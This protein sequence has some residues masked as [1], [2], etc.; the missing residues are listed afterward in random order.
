MTEARLDI[1]ASAGDT[2]VPAEAICRGVETVTTNTISAKPKAGSR[3]ATR[4]VLE[5]YYI[6]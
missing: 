1:L 6:E 5:A 3:N 2:T 4:M